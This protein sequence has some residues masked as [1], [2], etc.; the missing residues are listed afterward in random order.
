MQI[1][2]LSIVL[3]SLVF[4]FC[5]EKET[6]VVI[7]KNVTS[8]SNESLH[9]KYLENTFTDT[10]HYQINDYNFNEIRGELHIKSDTPEE[11]KLMGKPNS[12]IE[13]INQ[14]P[15]WSKSQYEEILRNTNGYLHMDTTDRNYEK[16]W[17]DSVG[18]LVKYEKRHFG[19]MKHGEC[20]LTYNNQK[21]LVKIEIN[22]IVK[23][24]YKYKYKTVLFKGI[25]EV[26]LLTH[27]SSK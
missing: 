22:E 17:Y 12:Y 2:Y 9:L 21:K 4:T 11:D 10:F 6:S 20:L 16:Y 24:V 3:F 5:N 15:N 18:M 13:D 26:T 19:D 14:V 7:S 8:V 23:D 25:N 1:K 27:N